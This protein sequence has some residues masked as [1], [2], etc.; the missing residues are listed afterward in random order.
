MCRQQQPPRRNFTKKELIWTS[1]V[2][3][4][5]LKLQL[6]NMSINEP[7]KAFMKEHWDKWMKDTGSQENTT[8]GASGWHKTPIVKQNYVCVKIWD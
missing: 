5:M 1:D 7:F 8:S 2:S 6:L 4:L 3:V